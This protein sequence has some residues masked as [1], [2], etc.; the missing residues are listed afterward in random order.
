MAKKNHDSLPEMKT[1]QDVAVL[2]LQ[3][4][5]EMSS[6]LLQCHRLYPILFDN[7]YLNPAVN[8]SV[9]STH[10]LWKE[11]S[12]WT[13]GPKENL[14]PP[15]QGTWWG[16]GV[17][18]STLCQVFY[19]KTLQ[20]IS[21]M[22]TWNIPELPPTQW[23]AKNGDCKMACLCDPMCIQFSMDICV[24]VHT[25]THIHTHTHTHTPVYS[26]CV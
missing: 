15:P 16:R 10:Y 18:G 6:S 21:N 12:I 11:W 4:L 13:K 3:D 19:V 14:N 20:T 23:W 2:L 22:K 26:I 17:V 25:H 7:P 24:C 9:S 5:Q 1:F 8:T